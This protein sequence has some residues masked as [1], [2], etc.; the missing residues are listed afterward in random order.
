MNHNVN[1]GLTKSKVQF[2][3]SSQ[4]TDSLETR[5]VLIETFMLCGYLPNG[6]KHR[7][8]L[9]KNIAFPEGNKLFASDFVL[10]WMKQTLIWF[11]LQRDG[12]RNG[13]SNIKETFAESLQLQMSVL[14]QRMSIFQSSRLVSQVHMMAGQN[15]KKKYLMC[16]IPIKMLKQHAT[17][18]SSLYNLKI[19]SSK[20]C[21]KN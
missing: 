13:L 1:Y 19:Y 6:P 2:K 15:V 3:Y 20:G 21:T 12:T 11:N 16:Q 10:I 9:Q 14:H 18:N 8:W 17:P 5:A 7:E 4:E